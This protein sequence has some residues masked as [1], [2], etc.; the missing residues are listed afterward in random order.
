MLT[1]RGIPLRQKGRVYRSYVQSVMVYAS[2]TWTVR[3]EEEQRMERN[4]NVMLRW[5]CGVTLRDKIPTV[6]LRRRLGIE[7][8]VEVM[9][10]DRL[11]WFG[12]VERKEVDDWVSACRNLEVA[13]RPKMTWRAR[14]DEDMKDMG[15][16][17]GMANWQRTERSGG[18]ASWGER[19]TRI[20]AE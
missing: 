8:V 11:R 2:E 16:R 6:E 18:V 15:L 10:W 5:M 20:S 4:E 3:V 14:L 13:G 19:L 12:H 7:G 1:R 17:P 9:K